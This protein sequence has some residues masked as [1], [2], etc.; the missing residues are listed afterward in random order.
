[1]CVGLMV[2]VGVGFGVVLDIGVGVGL[3]VCVVKV[4]QVRCKGRCSARYRGMGSDSVRGRV[5]G[6][7][8]GWF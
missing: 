1:M 3:R 7:D 2:W 6:W 8:R 4:L 5:R